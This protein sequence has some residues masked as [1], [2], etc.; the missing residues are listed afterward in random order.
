MNTEEILKIVKQDIVLSKLF[1]GVFPS[2]HL[3]KLKIK[4]HCFISNTEPSTSA[5]MH[6]NAWYIDTDDCLDYFDSYGQNWSVNQ[7]YIKFAKSMK[8]SNWNKT[9]IQGPLSS[10]CGQY[11]VYFLYW[12]SRGVPMTTITKAFAD[13]GQE[14]DYLVATFINELFDVDTDVYNE[15]FL[16]PQV[17]TTPH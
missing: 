1:Q 4:P 10:T 15:E 14:N 6:W 2:N 13:D 17:Q 16:I 3:P 8:C 11:C 9:K 7:Y 12:R 5:G